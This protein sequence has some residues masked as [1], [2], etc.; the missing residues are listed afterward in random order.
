MAAK[1]CHF[2]SIQS[3][4]L[5]FMIAIAE[6]FV[7]FFMP[8]SMFRLNLST[9]WCCLWSKKWNLISCFCCPVLKLVSHNSIVFIAVDWRAYAIN[10]NTAIGIDFDFR[11]I[12]IR[13]THFVF[14]FLLVI[15][16]FLLIYAT[17][18][19]TSVFQ[20]TSLSPST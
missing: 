18:R 8:V 19:P 11:F 14:S 9:L 20:T 1:W 16:S 2:R 10:F 15:A 17:E 3:I 12:V 5:I 13:F 4:F 7:F 6:Q